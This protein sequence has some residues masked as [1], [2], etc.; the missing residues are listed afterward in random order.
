MSSIDVDTICPKNASY[1]TINKV[2]TPV[3][4][5][6]VANKAY[7]DYQVVNN[8]TCVTPLV[9]TPEPNTINI[10]VN[11]ANGTLPGVIS[12]AAQTLGG[13]LTLSSNTTVGGTLQLN[14]KLISVDNTKIWA[15]VD[16]YG[17]VGDG[18][19]DDTTAIQACIS[20]NNKVIFG[21]NKTYRITATIT[22]LSYQVVNMNQSTVLTND[23]I[24]VT[25][26]L[27]TD[28]T[29]ICYLNSGLFNLSG[30]SY[31]EVYNGFLSQAA[32]IIRCDGGAGSTRINLHNLIISNYG[33][34][35]EASAV[36]SMTVRNCQINT[37]RNVPLWVTSITN[38]L[39][40]NIFIQQPGVWGL[41]TANLLDCSFINL[42]YTLDYT[43]YPY[44]AN[45]GSPP[46][47]LTVKWFNKA[48]SYPYYAFSNGG[49]TMEQ[50]TYIY[51]CV[52]TTFTNCNW[53]NQL[54]T[55]YTRC[56]ICSGFQN[57][58]FQN[59]S[60]SGLYL[61]CP[62][63]AG[64][65]QG[66]YNQNITFNDCECAGIQF[67]D[68][69]P[70][71]L[72][73]DTFNNCHIATMAFGSYSGGYITPESY[74][75]FHHCLID[76]P[77]YNANPD[78]TLDNINSDINTG[79]LLDLIFD[80][81]TIVGLGGYNTLRL[82]LYPYNYT[83]LTMLF[84]NCD[85]ESATGNHYN[86]QVFSNGLSATCA[87]FAC[88][89]N[90]CRFQMQSNSY[91]ISNNY[92][93]G[94]IF[95]NCSVFS[96]EPYSAVSAN[97]INCL[98]PLTGG[99][100][101]TIQET[102]TNTTASTSPTTG[103]FVL[104]GGLGA[105]SVGT[106]TLVSTGLISAG[107]LNSAVSGSNV[108]NCQLQATFD[109]NLNLNINSGSLLPVASN[110]AS[111]ALENTIN[112]LFLNGSNAYVKYPIS[113]GVDPG[114]QFTIRFLFTPSQLPGG[115]VMFCQLW[116]GTN[117]NNKLNFYASGTTGIT[118]Y[119]YNS[120]SG[121]IFNNQI[122]N[123]ISW[124]V[125]T[126]YEIELDVDLVNGLEQLFINGVQTG[127]VLHSTGTRT[128]APYLYIGSTTAGQYSYYSKF[129]MFNTVQH[130][131]SYTPTLATTTLYDNV[132]A[133][134][135][136]GLSVINGDFQILATDANALTVLGG[137]FVAGNSVVSGNSTIGGTSTITGAITVNSTTTSTSTSTG[138][139]VLAGGL[140]VAGSIYAS[141]IYASNI[142][143]SVTTTFTT[144]IS[145]PWSGNIPASPDTVYLQKNGNTV[146]LNYYTSS[147]TL[148]TETSALTYFNMN[149]NIP[150]GYIPSR[151]QNL[152]V[153]IAQNTTTT[154]CANL[155]IQQN[156]T[157]QVYLISGA[158]SG[159]CGI[160]G[161][162][163]TVSYN[164]A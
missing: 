1:V 56:K 142:I 12:G 145:G 57:V 131:S 150:A 161:G 146:V 117:S 141:N 133:L 29:F 143:N 3:Y 4:S 77:Y 94:V 13:A 51:S 59:C 135:I 114:P 40:E 123:S 108:L 85:F 52:N 116:N 122:T 14:G 44:P 103:A 130:T 160:P 35:I 33:L 92:L 39:F 75:H 127:N 121:L 113:V 119:L 126:Q 151:T 100:F 88:E 157:W 20:A 22:L 74:L 48:L 18:L 8:I 162:G 53:G 87:M 84:K 11:N 32:V 73:Q 25:N 66:T 82:D 36:T 15:C 69:T 61:A 136:T 58:V 80:S 163:F 153:I 86:I 154:V 102:N 128:G 156:G 28:G 147:G 106:G 67:V 124:V 9:S 93:T 72:I 152:V 149:T 24:T 7:V 31:V 140:G 71:V 55:V 54:A 38:G 21:Y 91:G 96:N 34:G 47:S 70:Y 63:T 37:G 23:G 138:S 118:A 159:T 26:Y 65:P 30:K 129:I 17:A 144:Q 155:I 43:K 132:I 81:C 90:G 109:T 16:D 78:I 50:M 110:A 49:N 27:N 2:R 158:F 148:G 5:W 107:G 76:G 46:T 10:S 134:G 125:G 137:S 120:T 60:F 45:A 104:S 79:N 164:I 19:T 112:Q 95:R 97:Y 68:Y 101:S 83:Y 6:E 115:T 42:D 139:A 99:I 41:Y 89:F 62:N 105:A 111:I 64:G 98:N